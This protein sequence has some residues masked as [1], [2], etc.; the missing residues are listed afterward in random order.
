MRSGG[1]LSACMVGVLSGAATAA[2]VV[3]NPPLEAGATAAR[4]VALAAIPMVVGALALGFPLMRHARVHRWSRATSA[5]SVVGAGLV[6][7]STIAVLLAVIT[8]TNVFGTF[9]AVGLPI[10]WCA[11]FAAALAEP[12]AH[13][14]LA[15]R[16]IALLFAV[17]LV[18]GLITF[19]FAA[20]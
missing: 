6:V 19:G 5:L 20:A 10:V 3:P 8:A 15:Q 9:L 4:F 17:V 11:V 16:L 18:T 7:A 14:T 2:L 12:L 1:L 13:R